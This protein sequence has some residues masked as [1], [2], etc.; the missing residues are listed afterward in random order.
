MILLMFFP[1]S[2]KYVEQPSQ[3]AS[4]RISVFGQQTSGFAKGRYHAEQDSA[5]PQNYT[6]LPAK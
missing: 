4:S 6:P 3:E 2:G 1:F 5:S